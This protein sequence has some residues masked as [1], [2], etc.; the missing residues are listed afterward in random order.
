MAS[1]EIEVNE[2]IRKYQPKL[3]GPFSLRETGC[4]GVA[5]ISYFIAKTVLSEILPTDVA[6]W[7][8]LIFLAPGLAAGWFKPFDQYLEV[9]LK[10]Y[11]KTNILSPRIRTYRRV[12]SDKTEEKQK[13]KKSK[14]Y[15]AH[16]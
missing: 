6:G 1:L 5:A 16:R 14:K 12:Y 7:F 9:F 8:S 3:I 15:K 4:L 10:S 11:I 2:D 13:H